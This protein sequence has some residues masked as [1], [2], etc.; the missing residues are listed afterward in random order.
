MNLDIAERAQTAHSQYSIL[1]FDVDCYLFAFFGWFSYDGNRQWQPVSIFSGGAFLMSRQGLVFVTLLICVVVLPPAIQTVGDTSGVS[2][3]LG[4]KPDVKKI[5]GKIQFVSSFPDYKVQVVDSFPDLK[6]QKVQ[7]F[8]N[9]PGKWQ[10][11]TS[12]PDYKIQIVKS[13]PDFKIKYVTSFPG[14]P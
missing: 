11:V 1:C 6:V 2:T 4:S 5:Y 12:F 8:P 14:A 7:S 3:A 9:K 10:I 13:F